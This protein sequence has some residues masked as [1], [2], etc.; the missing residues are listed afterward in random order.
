MTP[1]KI[2]KQYFIGKNSGNFWGNPPQIYEY[3]S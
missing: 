1:E 2:E 3:L